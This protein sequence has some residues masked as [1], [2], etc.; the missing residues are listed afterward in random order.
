MYLKEIL[1]LHLRITN[2][3]N[4]ENNIWESITAILNGTGTKEQFLL[5]NTWLE[6]SE[7]NKK[8]FEYLSKIR[9]IQSMPSE[10]DKDEIFEKIHAEIRNG[11]NNGR[12]L[13][14]KY[15]NVAAILI[16]FSLCTALFLHKT[17]HLYPLNVQI[18]CPL[19]TKS[20]V[21][22]SDGTTVFLNS[23]SV[24]EYPSVFSKKLREVKL[25]GEAFFEVTHDKS[26]E[27]RVNTG[28]ITIKVY[29]TKFNVKNYET[30]KAIETTLVEG[31]VGITKRENSLGRQEVILKPNEQA[32]FEKQT[33]R[34]QRHAI[35]A[36]SVSVWKDGKFF[37]EN[38]TF[39]T[40]ALELQR[41]FNIPIKITSQ[42]L[43]KEVFT[44]MFD[45][46]IT[47][48]KMLE[49]MKQNRDFSYKEVN[50]TIIITKNKP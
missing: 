9:S 47:I 19:G 46:N 3:M 4:L 5:L 14:L 41:E 50:D 22:L 34:I 10:A 21:I 16:I 13:W 33:E 44:G 17:D 15:W 25:V 40:I 42:S 32:I 37:F 1:T 20:K 39:E 31:S 12:I 45:R 24:L 8:T 30:D 28:K 49:S 23:G 7:E 26:R 48:Y 18:K 35:D 6:E 27:F 43:R 29:G 36:E 11:R 38:S 2:M